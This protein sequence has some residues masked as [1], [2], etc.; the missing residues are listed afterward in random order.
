MAPSTLTTFPLEVHPPKE[1]GGDVYIK[2]FLVPR[3]RE[4]ARGMLIFPLRSPALRS[5]EFVPLSPAC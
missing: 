4:G 1:K 2:P 3:E 5:N